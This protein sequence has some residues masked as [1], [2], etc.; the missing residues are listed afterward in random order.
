LNHAF[1]E[2]ERSS[3]ALLLALFLT[4]V[5]GCG[6]TDS[7]SG[8]DQDPLNVIVIVADDLGW[9]DVGFHGSAIK[10]PTLD[11]LSAEGIRLREFYAHPW[12]APTGAA[13]LTGMF[14]GCWSYLVS[15]VKNRWAG[16]V[17][18]A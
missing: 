15:G 9:A 5:M 2:R 18:S 7:D 13:F 4:T 16:S 10:T 6:F 14:P 8:S 1:H 17:I 11:A 3:S 12:C